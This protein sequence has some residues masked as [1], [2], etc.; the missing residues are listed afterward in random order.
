MTE[1]TLTI[2]PARLRRMVGSTAL[3]MR[4]TPNRLTSKRD[5][6]CSNDDSSAAATNPTPAL[7]TRRSMRP[8]F[9]S[10]SLTAAVT[11][12]SLVTS[13]ARYSIRG[14]LVAGDRR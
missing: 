14:D 3:V 10:T 9:D 1:L 6:A 11:D 5:F 8:A 2:R 4:M 7:L 12:A 13:H